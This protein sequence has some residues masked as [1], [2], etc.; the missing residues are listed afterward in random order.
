M[1]R[2]FI[3]T[4]AGLLCLLFILLSTLSSGASSASSAM[5]SLTGLYALCGSWSF[6]E[7]VTSQG[8]GDLF[9]LSDVEASDFVFE[10][11]IAF[12]SHSGAGSLIFFAGDDPSRGSYAANIDLS[13]GN[14]RIFC[15][16]AAGGATTKGEYL[17]TAAQKTKNSF[18]LRVEVV[19]EYMTYSI[20]G[21]T[22]VTVHDASKKPGSKLGL[23]TY[24]T[25]VKYSNMKY[26]ILDASPMLESLV[27]P[28]GSLTTSLSMN[29]NVPHGTTT[30]PLIFKANGTLSVS[31]TKGASASVEDD[32][33]SVMSITESFALTLTVTRGDVVTHHVLNV[34]IDPDPDSVYNEAWRSQYHFSPF[35]NWMNDPNGLVYDPS[36][37]SY[38]LFFQYNPFGLTIANQVW[39]HAVSDDLVHWKE[40]GVAIDQDHLGAV[41]SGSAVVDEHNTTGFFTDNTPDQSKLVAIYTSDGGDTTYGVEKQC[42]AY[43]KDHGVTWTRPTLE[44]DGFENPIISNENNKYG[45]DFRD[46]KIFWYDGKWFMVVA[47]GRARLFTSD[48]LIHWTLVSDMGFDSECPDFYPLAVDGDENNIKWV[49]TASGKWYQVG[50]L[51]K[52]SD[53]SYRF[54]A[55]GD[56]VTYNGGGEVYATQSYYNDGSGNNRRIAISWIQDSSASSLDGKTWNGAMTL[57]YEQTLR[58]VNGKILLC[59]YPV[60]EVDSLRGKA[61]LSLSSPSVEEAANALLGHP[62]VAYDL[63]LRLKPSAGARVTLE[64]RSNG[65]YKTTL[66]Y[67]ADASLLSVQRAC[68]GSAFGSIPTG[69]MEMPLYPDADGS[70]TLRILMDKTVIEAFGNEGEATLCGMIF[71]DAD[72]VNTYLKVEGEVA[73]ESL[74]LW[75]MNSV[76][77]EDRPILPSEG[78]YFE[79][80]SSSVNFDELTTVTA[81]LIDE[82][83]RRKDGTVCFSGMD[84]TLIDSL[85]VDTNSLTFKGVKRGSLVIT[86][87]AEG[88]QRSLTLIVTDTLF[89]TNLSGWSSKGDWY[90][91]EHGLG[92]SGSSGDSFA[93]SDGKNSGNFVYSGDAWFGTSGGCLG[94]V[95]GV[96][97]PDAPSSGIWYGANIDTHGTSPVMKLFCNRLGQ[98]IWAETYT[99]DTTASLWNLSVSY[100]NGVLTYTVNGVSRS[101]E[102]TLSSGTLGLVSWNGG[103]ALDN[104]VYTEIKDSTD[105]EGGG[106]T[107]TTASLNSEQTPDSERTPDTEEGEDAP[108]TGDLTVDSSDVAKRS[109]AVPILLSLLAL[110]LVGC[111]VGL[112]LKKKKH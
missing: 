18:H 61:L 45:R 86:A 20:D 21:V 59:S 15:F 103:G 14:A 46:P 109:P 44:T 53:T 94:L 82:N 106:T 57:P 92:L 51:Q 13:A 41:F 56:R 43:S 83:G 81:Y 80:D 17:L 11:D 101:H 72:C 31:A 52:L 71:P 42:I 84:E 97:R 91:T 111:S 16:E 105:T 88:Y 26:A 40:V 24:N 112:A 108:D 48:D 64:L 69:N 6:G 32:R 74:T 50:T 19:G 54:V 33:I 78:L 38:H 98:E 95:F 87:S 60:E 77:H 93:F 4:A 76:W 90:E 67:D 27:T 68:A 35:V 65:L 49:Y 85:S 58:T 36:D 107:E 9:A 73:I 70:V 7:T 75:Q 1:K 89:H 25:G 110:L 34:E 66:I 2:L 100:E 10:A 99:F 55:E 79:V 22:V 23:L 8:T 30:L 104:V 63:A 3:I 62:S 12:T 47:G 5:T 28:T 29:Y 96:S 102:V 37:E 39:A